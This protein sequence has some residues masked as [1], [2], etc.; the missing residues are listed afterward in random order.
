MTNRP[1]AACQLLPVIAIRPEPGLTA[2]LALARAMRLAIHGCALFEG[3]P[4]DWTPPAPGAYA[5]LLAA[6]AAL[7]RLAGPGLDGLR[8]LPVHAVGQATAAVARAAGFAVTGVGEGGLETVVGTLPPGHY[9]RLAGEAHVPLTPA[10]DVT[11]DTQ[12]VY[13]MA[14]LPIPPGLAQILAAPALVLLHSGEA[15]RHFAAKCDARGLDRATIALACLAPRIA[16]VVGPGWAAVG[17]APRRTDRALLALAGQMCQT[18]VG[19]PASS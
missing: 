2:T 14:A 6:S 13:R 3:A 4:F 8:A 16:G 11:I 7:F 18:G 10:P 12:V 5:G 15:A 17:I 9:L 19:R 1:D